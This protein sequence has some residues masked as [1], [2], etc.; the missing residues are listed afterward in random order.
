MLMWRM[1]LLKLFT[2]VFVL[3]S[4]LYE[5]RPVLNLDLLEDFVPYWSLLREW[6]YVM[7]P[8]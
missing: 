4:A 5:C 2:F 8:L 6:E 1:F 3:F 7:S